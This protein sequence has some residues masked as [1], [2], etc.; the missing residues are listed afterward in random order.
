M[1]KEESNYCQ[2]KKQVNGKAN[3]ASKKGKQEEDESEEEEEDE[4]DSGEEEGSHTCTK[5]H[6]NPRLSQNIF[7]KATHQQ[8]SS[9]YAVSSSLMVKSVRISQQFG[10]RHINVRNNRSHHLTQEKSFFSILTLPESLSTF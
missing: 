3:G 8:T 9:K 4:E 7:N 5:G 1:P 6:K 2:G 10:V